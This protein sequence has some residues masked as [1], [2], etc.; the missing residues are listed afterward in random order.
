MAFFMKKATV[1]FPE[2]EP[3]RDARKGRT[4][5]MGCSST[6]DGTMSDSDER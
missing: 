3:E 6:F 5:S 4:S 2:P 1:K